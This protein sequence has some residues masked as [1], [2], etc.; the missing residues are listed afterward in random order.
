M[1]EAL[2]GGKSLTSRPGS[3]TPKDRVAGTHYIRR[4]R[5]PHSRRRFWQ[6]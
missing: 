3:F 4:L 1:G 2:D 5:E 6:S